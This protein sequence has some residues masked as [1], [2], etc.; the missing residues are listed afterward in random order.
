MTKEEVI[1][2]FCK[3]MRQP[4]MQFAIYSSFRRYADLRDELARQYEIKTKIPADELLSAYA[5]KQA[6]ALM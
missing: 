1:E 2:L 5:I 4:A 6:K 3:D